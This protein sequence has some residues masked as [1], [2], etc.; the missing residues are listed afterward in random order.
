MC[1]GTCIDRTTWGFGQL[2]SRSPSAS[3]ASPRQPLAYSR[4]RRKIHWKH[5][6]AVIDLTWLFGS[7]RFAMAPNARPIERRSVPRQNIYLDG[8]I[9]FHSG[10]LTFDCLV[11]NWSE[12]GAL[13]ILPS[14]T[15]GIPDRFTLNIKYLDQ[16][17]PATV[18]WRDNSSLGVEYDG[19][20]SG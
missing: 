4:R 5:L 16:H 3:P 19:T 14:S 18:I 2:R 17:S 1:G 20:G 12:K 11:S 8:D 10:E 7:C 15:V 9:V 6:L 13:V